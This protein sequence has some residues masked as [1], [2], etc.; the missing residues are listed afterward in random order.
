V[1]TKEESYFAE[2]EQ[3]IA[4][5]RA[6]FFM[7]FTQKDHEALSRA[8]WTASIDLRGAY[9]TFKSESPDNPMMKSYLEAFKNAQ[10]LWLVA[11][12]AYCKKYGHL[13]I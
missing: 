3:A 11:R 5:S 9:R 13:P 2:Y 7:F 10:W 8:L 1:T 12:A 4:D 6:E